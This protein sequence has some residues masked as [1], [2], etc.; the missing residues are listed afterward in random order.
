MGHEAKTLKNKLKLWVYL[1]GTFGESYS[2]S[3]F[4]I[5]QIWKENNT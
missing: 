3:P 5:Q 2:W 1:Q 4:F